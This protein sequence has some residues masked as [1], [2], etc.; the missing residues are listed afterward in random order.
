MEPNFFGTHPPHF[1]RKPKQFATSTG[2][3]PR[4][5]ITAEIKISLEIIF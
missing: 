3:L 1:A 2:F 4:Q 5:E